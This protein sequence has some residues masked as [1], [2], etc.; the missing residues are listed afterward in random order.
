[1]PIISE[2]SVVLGTH[3]INWGSDYWPREAGG[4]K[5]LAATD[6]HTPVKEVPQTVYLLQEVHPWIRWHRQAIDRTGGRKTDIPVVPRSRSCFPVH[7][8]ALIQFPQVVCLIVYCE[9]TNTAPQ[10]SELWVCVSNS[11]CWWY[12]SNS[13]SFHWLVSVH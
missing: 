11:C 12:H 1:M 13:L 8:L 3:R 9:V 7:I 5:M 2:G 4:C 6:R 10:S